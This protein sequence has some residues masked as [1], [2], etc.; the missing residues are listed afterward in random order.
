MAE[1][2]NS[3]FIW[4]GNNRQGQTIKGEIE[5]KNISLIK[6]NLRRQGITSLKIKKKPAPLFSFSKNKISPKEI[7]LFSRQVATMMSAGIPM[8]QSFD[9]IGRSHENEA[10][11]RLAKKIRKE[12]EDGSTFAEALQKYPKHFDNLFCNLVH[13]GEQSGT[14]ETLLD[15]IAT[16]KER[17]E[18]VKGKIKKALFYP[19]AIMV[20]AFI[21][22]A[23][24]LIFVIP[25]FKD[26][27][28]GFGADLPAITLF[29]MNLS[30]FFKT[31]WWAIFSGIGVT[32]YGLIT[33]KKRSK[34]IE[35]FSDK[36]MLK[37]PIIGSALN[38]AIISRYARTL[39]TMFT[40]GVPLVEAL[41]SVANASGNMM[42]TEGILK[43]RDEV[44]TGSR[45]YV[46][47][48]DS[49]LFP[50]MVVQ[51]VSIGEEA[52]SISQMLTKI[53]DTYEE[54]VNN[55][56]D[57]LSSL[58]EPVIM[59]ILGVIIGGLVIAMYLPIFKMGSVI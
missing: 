46:A 34:S 31:W 47:M 10:M 52:G 1:T 32:I 28:T 50:D 4:E 36:M 51:M 8:I 38:K 58:M 55:T 6:A 9:L 14:L 18:S 20:V 42:Y 30:E 3:T 57:S 37:I 2:K 25:K 16:Y 19:L 22:T 56:V 49:N 12:V 43:I 15:K 54:E 24:L 27:F 59:A 53:A 7:A 21:I 23:I 26:L 39:S 5:G 17:T 45:L 48:R 35:Y 40:A 33:A 41:K 13:A 44:S 29:V 11:K